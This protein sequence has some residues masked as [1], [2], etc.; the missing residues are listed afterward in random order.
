MFGWLA[1]TAMLARAEEYYLEAAPVPERPDAA[2]IEKA[3]T[4]AGF[5][6]RVVRRFRLGKGWEFVV[7]VEHFASAKDAAA[8]ASRLETDLGTDVTAWRLDDTAKAVAVDLPALEAPTE[9]AGAAPWLARA[10]A[11]HGGPTGGASALARAGAVHFVFDRTLALGGKD[12]TV[13]HDYWREGPARRLAVDTGGA[14]QDSLAV[15]TA[16]GAWMRVGGEVQTRDIGI[17]IG[18][19][20]AFAPEAVLTV[21]LEA[22]RLLDGPEVADFRALEGAESGVRF[23]SGGDE[24]EP[25]VS[26]I[27]LDPATG[28]L[29]RVRYVSEAGPI[30]FELE[31]WRQ[32][33]AGVLVPGTVRVERADGRKETLKVEALELLDHAPAATFEKPS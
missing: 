20:D 13:R 26:F 2:R 21:A 1:V 18:V 32:V 14:G 6:A 5:D 28:R 27:D 16:N 7:L 17:T 31:D 12:V 33:Q 4:A 29:L 19:V 11:A 30:T 3:V 15:A 9:D 25:G 22:A 8:A 23:G 10:R 24:S